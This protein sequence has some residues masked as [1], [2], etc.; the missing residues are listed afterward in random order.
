MEQGYFLTKYMQEALLGPN[1]YKQTILKTIWAHL[2]Q[3]IVRNDGRSLKHLLIYDTALLEIPKIHDL[4]FLHT[5]I[6]PEKLSKTVLQV[7][8][9]VRS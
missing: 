5:T 2:Q 9:T 6:F 4:L 8:V 7:L 1:T 3:D